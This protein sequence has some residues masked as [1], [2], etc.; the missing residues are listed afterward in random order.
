VSKLYRKKP[1]VI[2]AVQF[3]PND[4]VA[5]NGLLAW[6]G[7]LGAHYALTDPMDT[8]ELEI[9]TLEDGHDGRAKHVASAGDWIIRG[10]TGEVYACK[11]DIFEATYEKVEDTQ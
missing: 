2:Q 9:R 6:L 7:E 8:W 5:L 11:P 10:V 4:E 3:L 1:V